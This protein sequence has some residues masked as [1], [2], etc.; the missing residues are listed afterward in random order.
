MSVG[1]QDNRESVEEAVSASLWRDF[2][3]FVI[4]GHDFDKLIRM[5]SVHGIAPLIAMRLGVEEGVV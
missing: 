2:R 1:A 4:A 3:A 5:I